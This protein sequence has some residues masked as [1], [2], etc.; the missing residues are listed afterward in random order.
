MVKSERIKYIV[1]FIIN[2]IV[3]ALAIYCLVSLIRSALNGN[4]RFIYF[5]NI[6]NLIVGFLASVNAMFLL[7]S[8]IKKE[9]CVPK[10]FTLIK[11]IAIS[12]TTLTFFTVLFVIGPIDGYVKNYSG[13]NFLTHLI[14]PLSVLISYL[15][16]EEKQYCRW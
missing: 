13:R 7:I 2:V 15:F 3:F 11:V 10:I 1:A 9:N 16:L 12:M 8:V 5:T 14:I 4:N 6:S